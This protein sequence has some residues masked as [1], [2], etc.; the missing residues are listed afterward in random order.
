MYCRNG[1]LGEVFSVVTVFISSR[2]PGERGVGKREA[3]EESVEVK[4]PSID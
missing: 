4:L 3:L 1:K 2:A